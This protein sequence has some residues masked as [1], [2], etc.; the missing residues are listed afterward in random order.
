MRIDKND[1]PKGQK[2]NNMDQK[3]FIESRVDDQIDW[4]DRKSSWNKI[5][6]NVLSIV[7]TILLLSIIVVPLLTVP[8]VIKIQGIIATAVLLSRG[9]ASQFAFRDRWQEYRTTAEI[10]K[11]EKFLFLTKTGDYEH[12]TEEDA[13]SEFVYKIEQLISKRN[14]L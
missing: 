8:S 12:F 7:D 1:Q 13:F 5:R 11:H 10:L 14:S 3:T 9:L 2:R 6:Y 4:Y